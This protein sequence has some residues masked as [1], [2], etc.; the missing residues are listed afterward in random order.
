MYIENFMNDGANYQAQIVA[1]LLRNRTE[2]IIDSSLGGISIGRYENGREQG[3]VITLRYR[4]FQVNYAVYEHR[5]CDELCVVATQICTQNTP[6]TE[7][8]LM[9][10]DGKWD[11]DANFEYGKWQDCANW[12]E[13]DMREHLDAWMELIRKEES[14]K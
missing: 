7:I 10:R 5:N 13:D 6:T 2:M 14:E 8:M 3:Y 1:L 12:I 9:N 4:Y 11:V